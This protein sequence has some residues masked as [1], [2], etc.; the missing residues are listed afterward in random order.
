MEMAYRIQKRREFDYRGAI[1][2]ENYRGRK[3]MESVDKL[4]IASLRKRKNEGGGMQSTITIRQWLY[5]NKNR[6]TLQMTSAV[7]N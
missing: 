1:N 4:S 2:I 6:T 5:Y 7:S 3:I